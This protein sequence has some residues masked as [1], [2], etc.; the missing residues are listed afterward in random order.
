[1]DKIKNILIS[2]WFSKID[3]NHKE[4]VEELEN[5]LGN[6]FDTPFM[7]NEEV[8]THLFSMPRIQVMTQNKSLLFQMS[9]INASVI[10][11]VDNLDNDDVIL[12]INNYAQ[13]F[14]DAL[15]EVYDLKFLYTSIKL[16]MDKETKDSSKYIGDILKIDESYEDVSFKRGLIKD[17]YYINYI[18]NSGREYDFKFTREENVLEQDMFDQ[19][20]ITPLKDAHKKR[21]FVQ[22]FVEI[23][24]RYAF[25]T[26]D[27][28]SS[29][30]DSIRG[31]IIELKEI[32]NKKLYN[33]IEKK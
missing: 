6:T 26:I 5:E 11:N 29:G 23:N 31:M 4:K 3:Y 1:M 14:Y 12:L 17:D 16:E 33:E 2:Y 9:L 15:K 30:K 32:I 25:N 19:T 20:M 24:D 7:Y 28:Y 13:L 21:E 8:A 27:E 10:I 18:L 22:M